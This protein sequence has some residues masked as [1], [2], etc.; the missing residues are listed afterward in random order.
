[1][2]AMHKTVFL[3]LLLLAGPLSAATSGDT[4]T[5]GLTLS[6]NNRYFLKNGQ[7]FLW[8]GDT[9]WALPMKLT[10]AEAAE[11][12]DDTAASGFNVIQIFSDAFWALD[13]NA[14]T[15]LGSHLYK[16]KDAR[17]L[18]REYWNHLGWVVDQAGSRGIHVLL[19]I[20]G[21]AILAE[22]R[23]AKS[24]D[25]YKLLNTHAK[26]Y[27]YGRAVG[28]FLRAQNENII[29]CLGQDEPLEKDP[30]IP[31]WDAMAEGLAD[32]IN[33]KTFD[34]FDGNADYTTSLITYH[35]RNSVEFSVSGRSQSSINRR[36][37]LDIYATYAG[38]KLLHDIAL[39]HEKLSPKKP[40][41]AMETR[42]ESSTD[43]YKN[44]PQW[45]LESSD[46]FGGSN[47]SIG[48]DETRSHIYQTFQAGHMGYTYGNDGIYPFDAGWRKALGDEGRLSMAHAAKFY[49]S[50]DWTK[51]RPDQS[52][53]NDSA[54]SGLSRIAAA[55]TTDGQ[56]ISVYFPEAG[57]ERT[58]RYSRIKSSYT[59][60]EGSWYNPK[61]GVFSAKEIHDRSE[62]QGVFT[63][64]WGWAGAMLL[65]KG[66]ST[67]ALPS[68]P[69]GLSLEIVQAQ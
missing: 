60:I 31:G 53:I 67:Q 38:N 13:E 45:A 46:V 20:G 65:L 51:L 50:I 62:G 30:F 5:G 59:Q 4:T 24:K 11:Y 22:Y 48:G 68:T 32:G 6:P 54:G 15:A 3:L 28:H 39:T 44:W 26:R 52:L 55:Y 41:F 61:T 58:I 43:K 33:G 49:N 8:L 21:P 63:S 66:F 42:Y 36:P 34:Q 10:K 37:W 17:K 2:T 19:C 25:Y 64:P 7:P 23:G 57:M 40:A 16:E 12:L 1:M 69:K 14:Q 27:S 35:G 18:N 47:D 9:A 56:H 29:W